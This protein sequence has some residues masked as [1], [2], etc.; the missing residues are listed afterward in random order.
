VL[1]TDSGSDCTLVSAD[2]IVTN[3]GA[4]GYGTY[5]IGSAGNT[6][7]GAIV[8]TVGW[9]TVLA[10]SGRRRVLS[11]RRRPLPSLPR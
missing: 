3:S 4:D 2:S 8:L 9:Y 10:R 6:Y 1:S 7:T 5:A 11:P